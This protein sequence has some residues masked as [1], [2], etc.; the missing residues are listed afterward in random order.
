MMIVQ[1]GEN[2]AFERLIEQFKLVVPRIV[3]PLKEQARSLKNQAD[4]AST[5]EEAL[6]L[7]KQAKQNLDQY[8]E[9]GGG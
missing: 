4:R 3:E 5:L 6:Y 7:S 8:P 2:P 9:F 1:Y